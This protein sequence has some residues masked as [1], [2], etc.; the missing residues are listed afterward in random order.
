M[1]NAS[2][3]WVV[4]VQET[5]SSLF[6]THFGPDLDSWNCSRLRARPFRQH[7]AVCCI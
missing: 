2:D 7:S 6:Q 4:G 5:L 3:Y 1:F